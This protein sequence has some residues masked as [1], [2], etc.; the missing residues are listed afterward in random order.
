MADGELYVIGR[1]K[2]I[3]IVGGQNIFPEDVETLVNTAPG[4]Y[5]GRV[6]AF[7]IV[8]AHDTESLIV[9]A[10]MKGAYNRDRAA[11]LEKEIAKLV[12]TTVGTGPGRVCVCARTLDRKKYGRQDFPVGDSRALPARG[13]A[14]GRAPGQG[15]GSTLSTDSNALRSGVREV[16]E[17]MIGRH[18]QDSEAIVSSGLVDSLSVV[19]LILQLEKKLNVIIPRANLQPDDFDT[20]DQIIDTLERVVA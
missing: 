7:G 12:L 4:I 8:N 2:D 14:P 15:G 5:P 9:V 20:V 13:R 16:V 3:V 6:V 19:K 18:V 17:E 1:L 11:A 10:E